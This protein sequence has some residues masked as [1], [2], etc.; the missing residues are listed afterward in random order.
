LYA[1]ANAQELAMK[2]LQLTVD[3]GF[4]PMNYFLNDPALKSIQNR[5]EF[6]AVIE[7]ATKRHEAFAEKFGLKPKTILN[8]KLK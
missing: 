3:R 1:L 4:F 8:T 6:S 7:Q 5:D 2:N